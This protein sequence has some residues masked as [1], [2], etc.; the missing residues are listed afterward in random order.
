M[1]L[2]IFMYPQ[3]RK[4]CTSTTINHHFLGY[5]KHQTIVLGTLDI[6]T[7]NLHSC[8]IWCL[9]IMCKLVPLID[10][11]RDICSCDLCQVQ[12]HT[13]NRSIWVGTIS[14]IL[15]TII[16]CTKRWLNLGGCWQPI[17][18]IHPYGFQDFEDQY[19]PIKLKSAIIQCL[20]INT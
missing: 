7:Y 5:I 19:S 15:I 17:T 16:V 9:G 1:V 6:T 11:K 3:Y 13:Y 12:Y 18:I 2:R 14:I 8:L 4:I 20:D 10:S